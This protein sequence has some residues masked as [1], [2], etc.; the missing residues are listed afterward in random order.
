MTR[1]DLA[2]VTALAEELTPLLQLR[3]GG[4]NRH[5]G[6][7]PGGSGEHCPGRAEPLFLPGEPSCVLMWT[8]AGTLAAARGLDRLL[9][10]YAPRWILAGGI[11]GTSSREIQAGEV[12]L[13]EAV[14]FY[15]QDVTALGL[16]PGTVYRGQPPLLVPT[17]TLNMD[18]LL[19]P[20]AL[21]RGTVLTGNSFLDDRL[22]RSLPELWQ[23]R[24]LAAGAIDMESAAWASVAAERGVPWAVVR[25]V[26]DQTFS[27]ARRAFRQT[28]RQSGELL[29]RIAT[30]P[31][32]C[33]L[34][35]KEVLYDP[36]N[37]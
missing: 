36:E 26:S 10:R 13:A 12:V 30:A 7:R 2:V 9:D 19:P 16:P 15:D 14:G 23:Q 24:I 28:C 17:A 21:H 25:T 8:G 20:G 4:S 35:P 29:L 27:D 34:T 22:L 31:E 3:R 33:I 18:D 5:Q 1:C 6:G 37:H 11:A 32:R